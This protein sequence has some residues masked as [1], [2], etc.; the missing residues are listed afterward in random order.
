MHL[1]FVLFVACL[2][3][4]LV[5]CLLACLLACL[6]ACLLL[7]GKTILVLNKKLGFLFDPSTQEVNR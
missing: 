4:G 1:W 2:F 3:V 7:F 5:V 6:R